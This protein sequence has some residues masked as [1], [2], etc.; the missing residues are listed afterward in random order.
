LQ[1]LQGFLLFFDP[2]FRATS[3]LADDSAAAH[4]YRPPRLRIHSLISSNK[5]RRVEDER[6]G[7]SEASSAFKKNSRSLKNSKVP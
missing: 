7:F 3:M 2:R 1:L 5:L 4:I 6:K